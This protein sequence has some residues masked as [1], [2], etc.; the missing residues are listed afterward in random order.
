MYNPTKSLFH[1]IPSKNEA[2]N[3]VC[4]EQTKNYFP[5]AK[6]KRFSLNIDL[7]SRIRNQGESFY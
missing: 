5:A 3:S 1:Q 6:L 4:L 2:Q 7:E